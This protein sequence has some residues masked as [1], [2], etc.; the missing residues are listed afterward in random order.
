[1]ERSLP[2]RLRLLAAIRIIGTT[3]RH[4]TEINNKA[5][6]SVDSVE[7]NDSAIKPSSGEYSPRLKFH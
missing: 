1:M 3:D 7:P 4:G 2:R 5:D 6:K